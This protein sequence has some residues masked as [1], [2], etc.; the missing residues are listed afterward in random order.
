MVR[1]EFLDIPEQRLAML[2][3]FEL[4]LVPIVFTSKVGFVGQR[5]AHFSLNGVQQRLMQTTTEKHS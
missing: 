2:V 3:N 5:N 4:E 1:L